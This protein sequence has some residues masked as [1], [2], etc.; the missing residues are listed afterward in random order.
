[1]GYCT[2]ADLTLRNLNLPPGY[3]VSRRIEQASEEIDSMIGIVYVTP[4]SLSE[5]GPTPRHVSLT[6][7]R[8]CS[9]LATGNIILELDVAGEESQLHAYGASLVS[10]ARLM[11]RSIVDG[12]FV[13]EGVEH[14]NQTETSGN[15]PLFYNPDE[16]S[17][18]DSFYSYFDS[19]NPRRLF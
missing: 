12:S 7:K 18:V 15:A 9:A 6:I 11:L 2:Q 10:E 5:T 16:N 4:V 1:M 19:T 14:R 17:N 8:I 3:D 13:L